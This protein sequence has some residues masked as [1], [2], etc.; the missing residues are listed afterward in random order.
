MLLLARMSDLV[1]AR[2]FLRTNG[3]H[4]RDGVAGVACR[5]VGKDSAPSEVGVGC[6]GLSLSRQTLQQLSPAAPAAVGPPVVRQPEG[7]TQQEMCCCPSILATETHGSC[8][9]EAPP[10]CTA[11]AAHL[12]SQYCTH[13]L[14]SPFP[15]AVP[16]SP[17]LHAGRQAQPMS[18]LPC[19]R[20]PRLAAP[21]CLSAL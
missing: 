13:G 21:V 10:C 14:S 6:A 9:T 16:L 15:V 7:G 12:A 3:S 11:T 8:R 19:E 17:V 18:C 5:A 1:Q 20:L 2:A 4:T